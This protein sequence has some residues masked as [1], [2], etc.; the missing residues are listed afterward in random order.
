[1][2]YTIHYLEEDW[3]VVA[4]GRMFAYTIFR[5]TMEEAISLFNKIHQSG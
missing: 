2:T 3:I 4:L 1:M 5:G